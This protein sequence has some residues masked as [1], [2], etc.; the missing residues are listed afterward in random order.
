MLAAFA[1]VACL[2]LGLGG[3]APAGALD[4]IKV[5]AAATPALANLS[6]QAS[7]P[8][9]AA[10]LHQ[11]SGH[12]EP[13]P[14]ED[15]SWNPASFA[16]RLGGASR[17]STSAEV[18]KQFP[19]G[20]ST[21]FVASGADFPDALSAGPAAGLSGAPVVLTQKGQLSR[22]VEAQI[23]RLSPEKIV[24]VGGTGVV[25]AA[26]VKRLNAIA[27]TSRIGGGDRYAT[28]RSVAAELF[29]EG[30]SHVI[31]AT[32]RTFPDAL[33]AAP[34]ATAVDAPVLLV[35]GRQTTVPKVTLS[36]LEA[37]GVT[38]IGIAGG[39][40]AVSVGIEKQLVNAGYVVERHSGADRYATSAALNR[41]YFAEADPASHVLA[42]G[43]DFPDA[44]SAAPLAGA[45][46][47]PLM[48]STKACIPPVVANSVA[49]LDGSRFVVG[50]AA[51]LSAQVAAGGQCQYP[52]K[53]EPLANW[54]TSDYQFLTD[55][56][57]PYSDRAPVNVHS[58]SVK[59]DAKG[60]RIYTY[61]PTGKRMFHPVSLA[62]Y[63]ISA[64]LEFDK[65]GE[66][67]WMSRAQ[68][69][70][71]ALLDGATRRDGALWFPYQFQWN[72]VGRTLNAPWWSAMAQGQA[73][74]L[75]TRLY[76]QTGDEKWRQAADET[77]RSF[78]QTYNAGKPW[79]SVVVDGHLY[80]EEYAGNLPPLLVLNGQIF[81]AFGLYDYWRVTGDEQALEFLDGA[82]TTVLQR[83]MPL[84]R[85]PGG[86][87]YY[88]VQA[89]YCQSPSWQNQAYHVI[90]SWQLDTLTR[91]TGDEDF[92]NWAN[93]L[94]KDWQPGKATS[95][96]RAGSTSDGFLFLGEPEF[97]PNNVDGEGV[98]LQ[99]VPPRL[100][101]GESGEDEGASSGLDVNSGVA[102]E[103]PQSSGG[104][105]D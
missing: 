97:S 87:S 5:Q 88:C 1:S 9:S 48:L 35:D 27:P 93:L 10:F 91:L 26:V 78:P 92:S 8:V 52:V 60:V 20:I 31:L 103:R 81:S 84:V 38:N 3:V 96:A 86:V 2:S 18:A 28:S 40:G 70:G 11:A 75:F 68:A 39:T 56:P 62:Q 45:L 13:S 32:G 105:D 16:T 58:T 4:G 41:G 61:A 24:V 42:T 14:L 34:A 77:W 50:G 104:A 82:V 71:Q 53:T 30:A 6:Q 100:A 65:T 80:L 7:E 101:L 73:L 37:L 79:S 74:S 12:V 33:S 83:M 22:E 25:G 64:L 46:G 43:A 95:L 98:P 51:V 29:P 94:R 36:T 47:V 15:D 85:V 63:G 44:I 69:Q 99:P 23:R 17:Y 19:A 67:I 90:H 76:E 89:S 66:R 59:L 55:V 57:A 21:V 49:A 54:A 102:D 72:Y